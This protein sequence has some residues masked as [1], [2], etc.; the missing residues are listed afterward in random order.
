MV[1]LNIRANFFGFSNMYYKAK[2]NWL[3]I[4]YNANCS[5]CSGNYRLL[6]LGGK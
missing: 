3:R 5:Y 1:F 6:N 4:C 2:T